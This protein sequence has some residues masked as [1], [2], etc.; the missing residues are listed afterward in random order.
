MKLLH[1]AF[2][3]FMFF[4]LFAACTDR[5]SLHRH[6]FL[7]I[8]QTRD[9]PV[10]I[11]VFS[12]EAPVWDKVE[13]FVMDRSSLYDHRVDESPIGWLNHHGQAELAPDIWKVLKTALDVAKETHGAFDPTI[14][15]LVNLWDYKTMGELPSQEQIV[16]ALKLVDYRQVD[17]KPSGMVYLPKNMTLDLGGIAKGAVVDNL[18]DDFLRQGYTDFLIEAGGDILISGTKANEE[19]WSVAVRHPRK[20]QLLVGVLYVGEA[21]KKQAVV[22]S[23]DYERFVMRDG[24]RY[25]HLLDTKT[26]QPARGGCVSVT[27]IAPDCTLADALSTA[28]FVMGPEKGLAYLEQKTNVEGLIILEKPDGELEPRLTSGFPLKLGD[29]K[30]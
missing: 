12:K 30:L 23:G 25:H 1:K 14:L 3:G 27:V 11:V 10:S 26:G 7:S 19:K 17:M 6:R 20:T 28:A 5:I 22:T 9:I 4:V 21:G 8:S 13:D 24:I 15:P 29:I 18:A 16:E 2:L